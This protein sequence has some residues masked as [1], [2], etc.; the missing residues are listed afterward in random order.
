M[1]DENYYE[2]RNWFFSFKCS[3]NWE[4]LE[5]T[6]EEKI[7]F[8]PECSKNVHFCEDDKEL[9]QAVRNNFCVA[10]EKLETNRISA[11]LTGFIRPNS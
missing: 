7:R 8:C 6:G 11:I 9:T 3:A 10:F 4:S 1:T 5:D 2:I